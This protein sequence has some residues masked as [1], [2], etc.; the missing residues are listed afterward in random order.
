MGLIKNK[1]R[2]WF[3]IPCFKEKKSVKCQ[4]WHMSPK[5]I[6]EC[7]K[8]EVVNDPVGM[9]LIGWRGKNPIV[10]GWGIIRRS[11]E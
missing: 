9:V 6:P 5:N 11:V 10:I 3:S 7:C 2:L 4:M 8:Q 1:S